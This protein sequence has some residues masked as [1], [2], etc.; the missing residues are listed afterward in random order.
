MSQTLFQKNIVLRKSRIASFDDII[1]ID[2]IFIKT[3][4]KDWKIVKKLETMY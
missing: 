3:T 1:K 4:F 2:N